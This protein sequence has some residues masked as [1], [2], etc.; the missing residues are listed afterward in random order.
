[1]SIR[2]EVIWMDGKF[3]PY[4]QAQIHVLSHT[5]HYGLGVFEGIRAYRQVDGGGGVFKLDV[6]DRRAVYP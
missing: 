4:D 3:V 6:H 2:S 5:L 1:M